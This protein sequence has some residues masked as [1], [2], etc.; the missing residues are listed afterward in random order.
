MI[1]KLVINF[2]IK[3][4]ENINDENIRKR[5][6][7]LAGIIGIVSNLFLFLFKFI[8]GFVTASVSVTADAFNNLSDM[9]SSVVTIIGINLSSLPPD[10]EHP[11]GHGRIEY[12]SAFIVSFLVMLVGIQFMK[13]SF[14]RLINPVEV[15]FNI[16]P[17]VILLVSIAVKFWLSRFNKYVGLKI[18]STALEASSM[19]ALG[20]VFTSSCVTL[21]FLLSNFTQFPIDSIVGL[22]IS[23]VIF[24]QGF[25]LVKKTVDSLLGESPDPDLVKKIQEGV[26]SYNKIMGVHDLIIHNYGVGRVIAS[27]HAEVPANVDIIYLH[28]IIDLAERELSQKLNISLVIHMD[29]L[30]VEDSEVN[31]TKEEIWELLK[32]KNY[33]I[34]IHDFRIVGKGKRKNLIFDVVVDF[35]LLDKS[36]DEEK[37]RDD[38]NNLV[39]GIYEE[40]ECIINVDRMYS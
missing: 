32:Q 16:I 36:M 1:S 17:F 10:K 18:K 28:E 34:S 26:M 13:T 9:A 35:S 39:K 4:N 19:D 11:F 40:Y 12:I 21:S 31:S 3:D 29:P 14:Q 37:I 27:I 38:I 22:I 6:G 20:D 5:Y 23:V 7:Q 30:N 15:K 8:I 2:F 25:L 33:V 24:Y